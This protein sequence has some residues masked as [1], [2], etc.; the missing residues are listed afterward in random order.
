MENEKNT[1][2]EIY[3]V[4]CMEGNDEKLMVLNNKTYVISPDLDIANTVVE[5]IQPDSEDE[6]YIVKFT[7]EEQINLNKD[8]NE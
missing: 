3:V 5:M 1:F 8:N 6:L 7:R 4:C 2:K